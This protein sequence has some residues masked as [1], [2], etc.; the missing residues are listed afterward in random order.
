LLL[1]VLLGIEPSLHPPHGRVLPAYSSPW[2]IFAADYTLDVLLIHL[3]Q[4][5]TLLPE[6][7]LT[8]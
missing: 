8:H 5:K 2:L 7:N 3:A 6:G 1:F 4:A